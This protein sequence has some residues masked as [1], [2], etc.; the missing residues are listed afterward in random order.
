VR[1]H[2][3]GVWRFLRLL[4]CDHAE[5]EDLTQETFMAALRRPFEA[6]SVVAAGAYLRRVARN[7]LIDVRRRSKRLDE[8]KRLHFAATVFEQVAH[9]GGDDWMDALE[10]CLEVLPIRTREAL[11]MAYGLGFTTGELAERLQLKENGAK[12]LLQR[13]RAAI[14]ECVEGKLG[15]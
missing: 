2:Y 9:D 13:A 12:T 8:I 14:R 5:A 4:G 1:T 6:R 3:T 10:R 7:L 15:L 11:R